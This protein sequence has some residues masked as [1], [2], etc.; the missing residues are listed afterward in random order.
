MN[1]LDLYILVPIL[2]GFIIGLFR[3]LIKEIISL[4]VI[5]LG[6]YVSKLF[7][8]L[9]ATWI[10]GHFDISLKLAQ[11][12]AFVIIFVLV[13]ILLFFASRILQGII[14]NLSL[15]FIN[16]IL[17]GVFGAF[18]FALLV[19]IVLIIFDT[20]NEKFSFIEQESK[21]ASILYK[22]VKSIAPNLWQEITEKKD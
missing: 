12:I 10:C 3:G 17:G 21:E 2:L 7:S 1:A 14:K 4:I 8:S 15:G 19:S 5:I 9:V 6:I 11:P 20:L 16:A 22:S 18:K 13:A